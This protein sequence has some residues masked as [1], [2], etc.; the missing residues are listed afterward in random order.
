MIINNH[1]II[2]SH[3]MLIYEFHASPNW[4][5]AQFLQTWNDAISLSLWG[6]RKAWCTLSVSR[7]NC[8][9]TWVLGTQSHTAV[10]DETEMNIFFLRASETVTL[11]YFFFLLKAL[12]QKPQ[13]PNSQSMIKFFFFGCVNE[14]SRM[15]SISVSTHQVY[16]EI[17]LDLL[18]KS[19]KST[20]HVHCVLIKN[21]FPKCCTN[22]VVIPYWKGEFKANLHLVWPF[23][24]NPL[25][26]KIVFT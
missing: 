9:L 25:V 11:A 2:L 4:T 6:T 1:I 18:G 13:G 16:T 21:T 5:T 15:R 24:F 19:S 14:T 12:N 7:F 10:N 3:F 20:S 23:E 17:L 22:C 26:L 8:S